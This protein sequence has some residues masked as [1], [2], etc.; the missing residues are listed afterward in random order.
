MRTSCRQVGEAC[1]L[2]GGCWATRLL[3]RLGAITGYPRS[4]QLAPL[5]MWQLLLLPA[6]RDISKGHEL[7]PC[8]TPCRACSPAGSYLTCSYLLP[9]A[10]GT[11][12][13]LPLQLSGNGTSSASGNEELQ[14]VLDD[15]LR[16]RTGSVLL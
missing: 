16:P 10:A 13:V 9:R 3:G 4:S 2:L 7:A 5:L 14:S 11:E 15:F 8:L 1:G 12:V 6:L